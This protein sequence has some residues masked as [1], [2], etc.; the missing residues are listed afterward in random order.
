MSKQTERERIATEIAKHI[1]KNGAALI[2]VYIGGN[3]ADMALEKLVG[4]VYSERQAARK[5]TI[6]EIEAKAP[7][8]RRIDTSEFGM[9]SDRKSEN[10]AGFN[11]SSDQW[12]SILK[13]V[14]DEG[15]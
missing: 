14:G 11:E 8:D 13:E 3:G 10:H 6:A 2:P 4:L 12:R 1:K 5:Q 9:P 7:K 15:N